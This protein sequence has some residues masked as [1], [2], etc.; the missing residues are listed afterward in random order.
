MQIHDDD[1]KKEKTLTYS[2]S[3]QQQLHLSAFDKQCRIFSCDALAPT[4]NVQRDS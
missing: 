3:G 4:S 2:C 1:D